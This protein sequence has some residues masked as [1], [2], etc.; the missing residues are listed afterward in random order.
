MMTVTIL[1]IGGSLTK[2]TGLLA[3]LEKHYDVHVAFSG[4]QGIDVAKAHPPRAVILDAI[5][6]GTPGERICRSLMTAVPVAPVLHLHPGPMDSAQSPAAM[7]LF[8]PV[9]SKRLLTS[10]ERLLSEGMDEV[11]GCGPFSMNVSRRILI[12]NGRE[13]QLTPKLASLVEVFMRNPGQTIDRKVLMEKVWETDYLG[14]TRTLDVHIR[15]IRKALEDGS[16]KPRYL[17]TVR[18]VGY[19]FDIQEALAFMP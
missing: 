2:I 18:G 12:A 5:S 4:K 14:D 6:L 13:T 17:K 10:L 8:A 16:T 11:I 3:A 1:L 19:C 9:T 7:T 15:W